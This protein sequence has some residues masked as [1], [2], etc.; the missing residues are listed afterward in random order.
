LAYVLFRPFIY[1][2]R[3]LTSDPKDGSRRAERAVV[4]LGV[5]LLLGASLY[6]AIRVSND[7]A[8]IPSVAFG[9]RFIFAAQLVLL[10]FYAVLLLVVPLVRAIAS[11]E[12]PVEL[13]LKGPRYAEKE[14]RSAGEELGGRLEEIEKQLV[15][16]GAR[17]GAGSPRA[18]SSQT[19]SR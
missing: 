13:T 2:G 3:L 19:S 16:S 5:P 9:N 7:T 12:L 15:R 14:L 1:I 11:G 10:I 18:E 8:N 4:R 17:N 6:L